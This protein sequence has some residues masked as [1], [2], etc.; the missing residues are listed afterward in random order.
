MI[1]SAPAVETEGGLV[2]Q[3]LS[4]RARVQESARLVDIRDAGRTTA[5]SELGPLRGI[6]WRGERPQ[7]PLPIEGGSG[8][9]PHPSFIDFSGEA[10]LRRGSG[11]VAGAGEDRS[12]R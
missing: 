4:H 12:E 10:A 9:E 2:H 8:P 5:G 6:H 11:T 1:P 7:L 3:P